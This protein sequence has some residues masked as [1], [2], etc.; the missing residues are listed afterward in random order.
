[1]AVVK[2]ERTCAPEGG[3]V[4][5][6]AL[7]IGRVVWAV[8]EQTGSPMQICMSEI[9]VIIVDIIIDILSVSIVVILKHKRIVC[10]VRR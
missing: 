3:I 6:I 2:T 9:V 1:M 10:F 4:S 7:H 8:V 5:L